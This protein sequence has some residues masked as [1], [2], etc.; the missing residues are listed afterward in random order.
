METWSRP[1]IG[2]PHSDTGHLELAIRAQAVYPPEWESIGIRL[3][4]TIRHRRRVVGG[5]EPH[6]SRRTLLPGERT[7][8]IASPCHP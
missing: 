5:G 8:A 6:L 7:A 3:G 2:P 4:R 1:Q